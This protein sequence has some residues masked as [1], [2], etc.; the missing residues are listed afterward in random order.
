VVDKL[1]VRLGKAPGTQMVA[2]A[3]NAMAKAVERLRGIDFK[4]LGAEGRLLAPEA[5]PVA[6]G[7]EAST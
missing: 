1:G 3:F 4:G 2:A 5:A 6:R 7:A